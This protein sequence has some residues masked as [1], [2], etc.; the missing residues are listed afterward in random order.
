M[1]LA[2]SFAQDPS[3]H[4]EPVPNVWPLLSSEQREETVAVLARLLAKAAAPDPTPDPNPP[5]EE[6]RDD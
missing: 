2:L 6:T 1:Q 5:E 4:I 3:T